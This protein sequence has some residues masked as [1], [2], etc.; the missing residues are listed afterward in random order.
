MW[1]HGFSAGGHLSASVCVHYEDVREE[2]SNYKKISNRPDA[3]ILAYPV[4]TSG[5]MAHKDSFCALLGMKSDEDTGA[6]ICTGKK[7][8]LEYMSLERHVN[9]D[10]PPCFIWQTD[11]DELVPVENSYLFAEACRKNGVLY[12]Q[13]VFAQGRHGLSLAN[14]EWASAKFGS[15]YTLEQT[16]NLIAADKAGQVFI[17]EELK[18]G[19]F[20]LF[21]NIE[22]KANP[23][24]RPNR[25][26][27]VWPELAVLWLKN[28]CGI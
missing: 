13:H 11:T 20:T 12:A 3:A 23:D 25:E 22:N 10:T 5:A 27:E 17:P 24:V 14:D 16:L 4:I 26:V 21:D 2:N 19:L 9:P 7:E 6:H 8:E 1:I 18:A 15:P 28:S